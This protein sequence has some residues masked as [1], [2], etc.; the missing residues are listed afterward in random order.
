MEPTLHNGEFI[1]V[2]KPLT[3]WSARRRGEVFRSAARTGQEYI[4]RVIGLPAD[5][6][7]VRNGQVHINGEPID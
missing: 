6:V 7:E 2:N 3:V 1:I 4:K 5:V